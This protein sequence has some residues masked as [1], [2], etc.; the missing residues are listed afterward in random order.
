MN[1]QT[2]ALR[3][4]FSDILDDFNCVYF[5]HDEAVLKLLRACKEV[6]LVFLPQDQMSRYALTLYPAIPIDLEETK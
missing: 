2:E 3:K 4:R 6:G 5:P 1:T